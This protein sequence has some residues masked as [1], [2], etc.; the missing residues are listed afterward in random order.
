M[1]TELPTTGLL[2]GHLRPGLAEGSVGFVHGRSL[3]QGNLHGRTD[4][5][6]NYTRF[7]VPPAHRRKKDALIGH[8]LDAAG[9]VRVGADY[10]HGST[11]PWH[12][13]VE[14]VMDPLRYTHFKAHTNA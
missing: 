11:M 3:L 13:K 10:T 8:I 1:T 7:G 2:P 5:Y 4:N 14:E 9:R 12:K 6:F